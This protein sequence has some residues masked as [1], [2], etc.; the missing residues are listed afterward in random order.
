MPKV[1]IVTALHDRS[2][3][4]RP[5]VESILQQTL[6][7]FEWIVIDDHSTDDTFEQFERLVAA[8]RRVLLLRNAANIGQGPTTRKAF[9]LAR[10]EF[11]YLTDD[12]DVCHPTFLER[13]TGL[14]DAHPKVGLAYCRHR[15]LDAKG[16]SWAGSLPL[17]RSALRS[18][19]AELR[20][21]LRRCHIQSPCSIVR[22]DAAERAGVFRTFVPPTYV[23]YHCC[24]K[25]CLVA[26]AAYLAEPLASYRLHP[27]QARKTSFERAGFVSRQE[28]NSFDLVADLFAHLPQD[29]LSLRRLEEAALWYAADNLR[30][31][32]AFMRQR[33]AV[34][35]AR[36]LE[37]VVRRRV[38]RYP[39]ARFHPGAI[40]RTRW[41]LREGGR[42]LVRGATY[43]PPA[44]PGTGPAEPPAR[45]SRAIA[46]ADGELA[47][48]SASI[49]VCVRDQADALDACLGRLARLQPPERAAVEI[50]VVDNRST[51]EATEVVA[52][53]SRDFPFP[54]RCLSEPVPGLARARNRGVRAAHSEVIAFLDADC[55][56]ARDWIAR[57][58]EAFDADPEAMI[59]GG[60]VELHDRRDRRVTIKGTKHYQR[61]TG[62]HQLDGFL[63][64]CNFAFRR[65]IV[66]TIGLFDVRLG[67]GGPVPSA[68]DADFVYRGFRAGLKVVY[69]PDCVV[70]HDHGRRTAKAEDDLRRIYRI[71]TGAIRMKHMLAGDRAMT[72]WARRD[73]LERL[74]AAVHLRPRGAERD[75]PG[76][77]P[78]GHYLLGAALFLRYRHLAS[79]SAPPLVAAEAGGK[80]AALPN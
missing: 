31:I 12:D 22:R 1:S 21:L 26:D 60:R 63:H 77:R 3:F 18:G 20:A 41:A 23:D 65:R 57:I 70:E 4:L 54:L 42:R 13:M 17:R 43:L 36:D 10:G 11:V 29:R 72:A 64:G 39:T 15:Y 37:A 2:R 55:L 9:E 44:S 6:R 53:R 19:A 79:D 24:L 50:L 33:G 61:L 8:D 5:R 52:R 73:Y 28:K 14:L 56:A 58:C 68:E 80:P 38:P 67:K 34:E 40:G 25:T 7:D 78:L 75:R 16:G 71:G 76:L 51:D 66:A 49:I 32:F 45:P 59:L 47:V 30:P 48:K 35:T 46:P 74:L 27:A 69:S 62:V